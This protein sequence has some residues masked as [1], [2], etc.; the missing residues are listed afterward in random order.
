M[1]IELR[2]IDMEIAYNTDIKKVESFV[3]MYIGL[4]KMYRKQ[5]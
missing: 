2:N 5:H 3:I 4:K 1:Y